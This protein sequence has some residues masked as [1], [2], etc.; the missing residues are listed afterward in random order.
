MF[1]HP[2]KR[3]RYDSVE[4]RAC[5]LRVYFDILFLLLEH[6]KSQSIVQSIDI[7]SNNSLDSDVVSEQIIHTPS[8]SVMLR[9]R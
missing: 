3:L 6:T 5:L 1:S 7:I 4:N 2:A 8:S 9:L